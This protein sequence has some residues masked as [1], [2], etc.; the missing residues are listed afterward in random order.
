V[1]HIDHACCLSATT[2]V[3]VEADTVTLT[4]HLSGTPCRCRCSS[5]I[6]A[7]LDVAPGDYKLRVL[8]EQDG[9]TEEAFSGAFSSGGAAPKGKPQLPKHIRV[10]AAGE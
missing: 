4:E 7:D 10:P 2:D 8:T 3:K 9:K 6:Q 5:T 1:H